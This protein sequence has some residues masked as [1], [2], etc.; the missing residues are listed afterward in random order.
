MNCTSHQSSVISI[1]FAARKPHLLYLKGKLANRFTLIELLIVIAIIAI[2]AGMLLPALNKARMNARSTSCKSN[3]RSINQMVMMYWDDFKNGLPN[4]SP[5][6][7]TQSFRAWNSLLW[8]YYMGGIK[9][10]RFTDGN[11]RIWLDPIL[12]GSVFACPELSLK[13][14]NRSNRNA[15]SYVEQ[16]YTM[17]KSDDKSP[18]TNFK[19]NRPKYTPWNVKNPSKCLFLADYNGSGTFGTTRY[20]Y[21][22]SDPACRFDGRHPAVT[23][24]VLF[25]GGNVESRKYGIRD[26]SFDGGVTIWK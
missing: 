23:A 24:N 12:R 20:F 21:T 25:L 13:N 3:L 19:W 15:L 26:L 17:C 8:E 1:G 6:G 9:T 11:R 7:S 22:W 5:S 10:M 2:L 18:W 4:K 14:P 16:D